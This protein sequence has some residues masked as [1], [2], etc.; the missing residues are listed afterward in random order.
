[1]GKFVRRP[2]ILVFAIFVFTAGVLAL[3]GPKKRVSWSK[4]PIVLFPLW[5]DQR[6]SIAVM[7]AVCLIV[8]TGFLG[9][10]IDAG[11]WEVA[12]RGMQGAADGAAYSAESAYVATST[13]LTPAAEA[14]NVVTQAEGITAQLGYVGGA[15]V[16]NSPGAQNGATLVT[17]TVNQPPKSG[18]NTGI[19]TAIEVIVTQPQ[20]RIFSGLYQAADPAVSARAVAAKKPGSGNGCVL[21]LNNGG[22][23]A[24]TI[25]V[26][27]TGDLNAPNCDIAANSTSNT[28]IAMNGKNA[29]I[30]T[31]CAATAGGS[32][33]DTGTGTLDLTNP[34]CTSITTG[35]PT[36]DPYA[37]V[38]PPA[39]AP[40]PCIA[41]PATNKAVTGECFTSVN[42]TTTYNFPSGVYY[43]AGNFSI[44]GGATVTN[45]PGGVTFIIYKPGVLSITGNG[46]TTFTAPT[47]GTYK[48][49]VFFGDRAGTPALV[50]QIAGT[51][52]VSITG[53]IYFPKETFSDL[54]TSSTASVCTQVIADV[55]DIGG[56]PTFNSNCA[57]TG[58]TN[59]NVTEPGVVTLIE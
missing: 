20:P 57:G 23:G 44:S 33:G 27:G 18:P 10:A 26:H 9:F 5:K 28:P 19:A 29:L 58:V 43:I 51:V 42:I 6:G 25:T 45:S 2:A 37:S 12:R 7:T 38:T 41:L 31:P 49:I 47:S 40:G 8:L 21:A 34:K 55:V 17:V 15:S 1:M 3:F 52:N 13:T 35:S 14:I 32:P 46:N 36:A 48:G 4:L 22:A 30:T 56:T 24:G 39:T 54:G 50:N 16:L 11:S 59:I 53:A